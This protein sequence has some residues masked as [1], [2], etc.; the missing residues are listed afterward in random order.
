MSSGESSDA[1]GTKRPMSESSEDEWSVKSPAASPA[2]APARKKKK[3]SL[4]EL[5]LGHLNKNGPKTKR[6]NRIKKTFLCFNV[7]QFWLCVDTCLPDLSSVT[8]S[9]LHFEQLGSFD[10]FR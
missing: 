8:V 1:Q 10:A 9:C 3:T 4:A 6:P 5:G 2:K 7:L